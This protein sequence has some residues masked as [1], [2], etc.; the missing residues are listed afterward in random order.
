MCG[1]GAEVKTPEQENLPVL[2]IGSDEYEPFIYISDSKTYEG[3]DVDIAEEACRRIGYRAEFKIIRWD[4]KDTYIE[5]GDVD[6][7]WGSFSMDGREDAYQW[8]GP[9]MTSKQCVLVRTDSDIYTLNDLNGKKVAVQAT[10]KPEEIFLK[11]SAS[12]IPMVESVYS[13]VE[14]EEA[15]AALRKGYVDACASHDYRIGTYL[16]N[17]LSKYR[18]LDQELM[19]SHLGV[20]FSK[21]FDSNVVQKLSAAL[22]EMKSDG[23]IDEI[24]RK[25]E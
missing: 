25:Y 16:K 10:T 22:N 11:R 3:I 13:F 14:T 6:C 24:M 2:T 8:A 17:A 7:L 20:A 12:D 23:T 18:V 1:C 15:F 19:T 4:D 21:G 5:N 9:Y